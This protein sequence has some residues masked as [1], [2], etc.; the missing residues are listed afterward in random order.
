[1]KMKRFLISVLLFGAMVGNLSAQ[2]TMKDVFLN[3]PEALLPQL[4]QN[5]RLD[6]VDFIESKMQAKVTNRLDGQSEM[7]LLSAN[8]LSLQMNDALHIEMRMMPLTTAIDSCDYV[9]CML[10]TYGK[11][12]PETSVAFFSGKWTPLSTTDYLQLPNEQF[13]A[14][15][16]DDASFIL[17]LA[18]THPYDMPAMEGQK[19]EEKM[20]T[21]FKWDGKRFNKI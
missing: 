11:D 5:N 18:V 12:T 13:T 15:F 8:A 6:M 16:Q 4:T 1:M 10:A 2:T 14:N 3:M 7:L 19:E 17:Q 9:V 20:L 21:I